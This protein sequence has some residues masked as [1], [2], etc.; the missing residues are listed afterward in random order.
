M[1]RTTYRPKSSS[2]SKPRMLP[3]QNLAAQAA[4]GKVFNRQGRKERKESN[5]RFLLT[6]RCCQRELHG[7]MV[8]L[9]EG[10][11]LRFR[12]GRRRF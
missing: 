5:D 7:L 11:D 1:K 3:Q 10:D 4:T 6:L 8:M 12:G 2:L 9:P